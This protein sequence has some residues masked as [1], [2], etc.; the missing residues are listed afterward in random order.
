MDGIL[1]GTL[2]ALKFP[3]LEVELCPQQDGKV[4]NGAIGDKRRHIGDKRR[5]L[6]GRVVPENSER[7]VRL[8]GNLLK[9]PGWC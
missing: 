6:S 3:C 7:I 2:V 5:H 8:Q 1:N 9:Q 4:R